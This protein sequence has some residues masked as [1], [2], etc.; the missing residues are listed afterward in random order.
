MPLQPSPMQKTFR[1]LLAASAILLGA[2][3]FAHW[4]KIRALN[5]GEVHLRPQP[6]NTPAQPA[7]PPADATNQPNPPQE[8]A[9]NAPD[10][11]AD[12]PQNGIAALPA[13]EPRTPTS[14]IVA[15]GSGR[16]QLYRQGDLTFRLNTETG[17]ACV[18]FATV[19]QWSKPLVYDHGCANH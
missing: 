3:W 9:S 12:Q 7:S 2:L 18:L 1:L 16:F 4:T 19:S 5:S 15:A 8:V 10:A 17:Q 11:S 6:Q 13:S 14:G